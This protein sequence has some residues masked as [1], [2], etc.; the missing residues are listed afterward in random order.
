MSGPAQAAAPG[1][2]GV[3]TLR[4]TPVP[5]PNTEV[6]PQ[7]P[8]VLHPRESRSMPPYTKSLQVTARRLFICADSH[9]AD[10]EPVFLGGTAW[11]SV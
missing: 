5:I 6:K 3:Y 1:C 10:L 9:Q 4:A 7:R 11:M 2:G 8:M